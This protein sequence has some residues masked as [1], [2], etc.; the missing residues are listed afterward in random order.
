MSAEDET[1]AAPFPKKAENSMRPSVT[2][3]THSLL[4]TLALPCVLSLLVAPVYLTRREAA[5]APRAHAPESADARALEA[6]G[7]VPLTFEANRG[8]TAGEVDFLARGAGYTLFLKPSE[9]VLKLRTADSGTRANGSVEGGI[10]GLDPQS[11]SGNPQSAVLRVKLVGADEGAVGSGA[12]EAAGKVNYFTGSDPSAWRTNVPAFGRVR[13]REVYPGVDVV[14]YG[15]QRQL[16]YDFVVAPGADARPLALGF[17]GADSLELDA[18][19]DLLLGVGGATVRQPKPFVYQEVAGGRRE[20]E[21]GYVLEEG[22]HV[23][24]RLGEYDARLPLVI[25]PVLVYSTYLGGSGSDQAN[26]VRVDSA[27]NV[28]IAGFTG[29]TDFPTANALQAANGGFQDAFITKI[30][31]AGNALVYSTYFG[32]DAQEQAR[33][34]TIDSAGNAYITGQTGSTNFPTL[35]PVQATKGATNEDAFLTKINPAGDALVYSTYLGGGESSEFGQAVAVDSAGHAYITGVT[36]SDDFP[37]LNPI[38]AT[39]G[40]GSVDAYLAKF[41]VDG[42]SLV[43]S[44]YLGG[45]NNDTGF[46]VAADSSGN[47]YVVGETDSTN[48]PT[49]SPLQPANAGGRDAFVAKVNA[50]GAFIFSTYHGG[51]GDIDVAQSVTVDSAGLPY[52][53]GQTNSTNFPTANAF[54]AANGGGV[55]QD[56]FLTKFNADGSARVYSTYFGGAGGEIA[57]GV[58]VDTAGNPYI[59]GTTASLNTLPTAN[60][61]QCARAGGQDVFVAK[62]NAAASALV[63]STYLGGSDDDSGRMIAVDSAGNAYVTGMTFSTD[64]PTVAP[65]QSTFAGGSGFAGDAFLF[66]LSDASAG[67]ASQLQFTQTAPAIQEDVTSLT[68]TVQ[69]TGDTTGPV[70][71]N[72]ATADGTASERSDYTTALGTLRFAAGETSKTIVVLVNEDSKVEGNETFTVALSNPTGGA[73]LSCLTAVATVQ[74]TDDAVEPTTNAIDV[75]SIFVGQHY[76]DFLHRQH[77]QEGLDFWVSQIT[78]CNDDS[79]CVRARRANVSAAFFLSIEFQQTGYFVIRAHKAAFGSAKSNPRYRPFLRDQRQIGEGVVFGDPGSSALLEA[80]RQRYLEEF[81]SRPEFVSVFPAGT[82][83]ATYV[84]TLFANAGVTPTAEERAAA[85]SAYGT[86]D[87]AGRAAALRSVADSDSVYLAQ[88]NPAFVLMQYYGYMRRN[89]DDTPD[90]DFRG[91]DFWLAKM[92][93]FSLPGENVRNETVALSRVARAQMV[94]AFIESI[95]YRNRFGQ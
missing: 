14:Y 33:G 45:S 79:N 2:R 8:Q 71:V 1:E 67:P 10:R 81:V 23:R 20:V 41:S 12:E 92:D 57:F 5:P 56:A 87:T 47:A 34:F 73:T 25:D 89:P 48:F 51:S 38:Q 29:S 16:E 64:F 19:G 72:Y 42:M 65:I 30:N 17:E 78:A 7:Q 55:L 74:I 95:E 61:I 83:A 76:H 86:G 77:D 52:V 75:A 37:T 63:Y 24:F 26:G 36:F 82:P 85:I 13:Y 84:D 6:Y 39:M 59:A 53:A 44:T 9:A 60:A 69:R 94:E 58:A 80:N 91:Y 88:Y 31:P 66:K 35:N 43:Y 62:F 21:G 18:S 15:N 54:Q 90:V 46:G 49:A 40:G 68:L 50:T 32:G 3:T 22:G 11:A 27:G 93:S 28:Y 70:S 4:K